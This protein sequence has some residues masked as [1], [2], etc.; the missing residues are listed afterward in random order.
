[1]M[2]R[3]AK[4]SPARS[5]RWPVWPPIWSSP[6]CWS[7]RSAAFRGRPLVDGLRE[8]GGAA[9]ARLGRDPALPAVRR[10]RL[11]SHGPGGLLGRVAGRDRRQLHRQRRR[12]AG[13]DDDAGRGAAAGDA[14]SAS[15]EVVVV[16]GWAA[17]HAGHGLV[18]GA[19]GSWR[20]MR[21]AF[22]EKDD[23]TIARIAA[24]P[25][26]TTPRRTTI[27]SRSR[28][29][30]RWR[31]AHDEPE[32]DV[33]P[34]ARPGRRRA[35]GRSRADA[36]QESEGVR[37]G[38]APAPP[39]RR[40]PIPSAPR[41]RRSS[42]RWRPSSASRPRSRGRRGA[43]DEDRGRCRRSVCR[44]RRP[45]ARRA[46]RRSSSSRRRSR[47]FREQEAAEAAAA[48]ARAPRTPRA[49]ATR[50]RAS[51][52]WATAH[53]SCR[54]PICSSTSRRSD[55]T[56]TSRP[57]YD[58]AERLEQAMS[59]YGVRGKVKEIHMGPG[60]HDVRVRA[61]ARHAHRQDRQPR[62]GPGDGAGGA[63][64]PHRR[65]DPRQGRGRRRGAEQ[66]A[67]DGLPEGD[68]RRTTCFATATS[69][70]PIAL[71]KDIKGA[72]VSVEPVEDAA[73]AGRR[74]HRLGQVGRG[75]RHDHQPALQRARPRTSAS[76]WSTRRCS[77]SRSTRASR[78]CCCRSSP[79]RRRR[80]WRCAGRSTRWSAATS[81]SPR[82]ACAT[83]PAT[84]PGSRAPTE[85]TA[86]AAAEAA[87]QVRQ[88]DRAS[89][90]AGPDG[91][92]QEVDLDADA[93]MTLAEAS[94]RRR[95]QR[96]IVS[97]E[98]PSDEDLS[99]RGGA[100]A[101]RQGE[102]RRAGDEK[103][104]KLPVHRHRHRRVR[105]PHDGRAARTSRRRWRGW[106]R[107]RARPACT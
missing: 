64:G 38:E 5:T 28:S 11:R 58:M 80:T 51:S 60:R 7:R 6:G 77:S 31:D 67:R 103:P 17:R 69:K 48:A 37:V 50:S 84:T 14:R 45:A 39:S 88:E 81:C 15:H 30:P 56:R 43:E 89:V 1:M 9:A 27:T 46:T 35:R 24:R 98:A 85:R 62:E 96:G 83:S 21:A 78:T 20:V 4:R 101:G 68:P 22:P 18:A 97:Y 65:A 71:G 91:T 99:R 2:G 105:R 90:I 72:P 34:V 70:L 8:A 54:A 49:C 59:N 95:G 47:A 40:S 73:P 16:L 63:G 29:T 92:E 53:S 55:T 23:A 10:Q 3:A 42:P 104:T 57:L 94:R 61:G 75:Q 87:A 86:E 107:R 102:R 52:S 66:D 26:R 12:R 100:G 106:R 13:R 93:E 76:S 32:D 41:W 33:E 36:A 44:R 19:R 74:H 25:K 79:I 82:R